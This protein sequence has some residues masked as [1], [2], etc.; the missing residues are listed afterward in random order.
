MGDRGRG[1]T[2]RL[3]EASMRWAHAHW[4]P[5]TGDKIHVFGAT[6]GSAQHL[7]GVY[8]AT[9]GWPDA[10]PWPLPK[11]F[12]RITQSMVPSAGD[13]TGLLVVDDAHLV[14]NYAFAEIINRAPRNLDVFYSVQVPGLARLVD[15]KLEALEDLGTALSGDTSEDQAGQPKAIG[16]EE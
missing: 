6:E 8:S 14:G 9:N 2:T 4:R 13:M 10:M 5:G 1:K 16:C 3:V 7:M 11:P 15:M 12:T